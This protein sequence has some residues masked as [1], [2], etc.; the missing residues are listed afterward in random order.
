MKWIFQASWAQ[1]AV[2]AGF[3]MLGLVP[4]LVVTLFSSTATARTSPP[5]HPTIWS[6]YATSRSCFSG[7]GNLK[8]DRQLLPA[9]SSATA[10]VVS[11]G[12]TGAFARHHAQEACVRPGLPYGAGSWDKLQQPDSQVNIRP[13]SAPHPGGRMYGRVHQRFHRGYADMVPQV[14]LQRHLPGRSQRRRGL[15]RSP[16]TPTSPPTCS[17][18]PT[19][20][21]GLGNT[22]AKIGVR[23]DGGQNPADLRVHRFW[24]QR[25]N[26]PGRRLPGRPVMQYD[27]VCGVVIFELLPDK[28]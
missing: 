1:T 7:F 5:R 27:Y 3:F 18:A 15:F 9:G 23:L 22:F 25:T 11:Y 16:S 21:S 13:P 4:F 8:G 6:Q 12:F 26:R 2:D 19:R 28:L 24:L 14:Q 17:P 10:S 20:P